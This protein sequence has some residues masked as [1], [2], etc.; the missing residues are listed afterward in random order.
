[1]VLNLKELVCHT[2]NDL[3]STSNGFTGLLRIDC[4][5][6]HY[7]ISVTSRLS[8]VSA[9]LHWKPEG[10]KSSLLLVL[11][12]PETRTILGKVDTGAL[13]IG[14]G[15]TDEAPILISPFLHFFFGAV[16]MRRFQVLYRLSDACGERSV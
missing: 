12:V 9:R 14:P 2:I 1:M 13:V 5:L 10:I 8:D 11:S 15:H 7:N 4:I 16:K 6:D 3:S